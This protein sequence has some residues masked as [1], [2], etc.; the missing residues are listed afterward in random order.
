MGHGSEPDKVKDSIRGAVRIYQEINNYIDG[1][2]KENPN[3]ICTLTV[4]KA[5]SRCN[6]FGESAEMEGTIRSYDIP[7]SLKV[8]EKLREIVASVEKD[9]FKYEFNASPPG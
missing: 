4:F 6:V 8:V 5:G 7:F 3:F 2:R 9:G 1:I